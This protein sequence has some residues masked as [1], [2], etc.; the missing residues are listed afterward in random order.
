[1]RRALRVMAAIA[2]TLLTLA[3]ASAM[4]GVRPR[5][6]QVT[7]PFVLVGHVGKDLDARTYTVRVEGVRG[8]TK[9]RGQS[10]YIVGTGG[11]FVLVKI[12]VLAHDK[13]MQIVGIQVRDGAG[14]LFEASTRARNPF[15]TFQPGSPAE[16][17]AT[18]EVPASSAASLTLRVSDA[19]LYEQLITVSEIPLEITPDQVA[20]WRAST[21]TLNPQQQEVVR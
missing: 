11:V 20:Q 9:L 5:E 8:G 19:P 12:R 13:P 16:A 1:M 15:F 17:E 4:N 3:A 21:E 7:E 14:R 10:G 6:Y 2:L 18:F